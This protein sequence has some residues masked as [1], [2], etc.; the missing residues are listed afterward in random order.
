MMYRLELTSDATG[1]YTPE[2][3][4]GILVALFYTERDAQTMLYKI[5]DSAAH[6]PG[7]RI[8]KQEEK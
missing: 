1:H 8:V 7:M 3:G 5:E 6:C 4:K 2:L